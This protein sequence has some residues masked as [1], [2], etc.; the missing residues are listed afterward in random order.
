MSVPAKVEVPRGDLVFVGD[1]H[2]DRDDPHLEAFVSFLDWIG[3]TCCR[4]VFVGDLFNLWI[5]RR[6]LEGPH[7]TIVV[8]RLERLRRQGLVVRYIEG[9]RDYRIGSCYTGSA[10][11]EATSQGI[12]ECFG[13]RRVWA[14]HGDLANPGD[15]NYRTW[16]RLSRSAPAWALFHL[17]PR[18]RRLRLAA[19]LERRLRSSNLEFKRVFPAAVVCAYASKFLRSDGDTVVLGHFHVERDLELGGPGCR[20]RLLVL[21]EWKTS[22]RHLRVGADGAIGFVD[23]PT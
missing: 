20:G 14:T 4:V 23:S 11:D 8:K 10:F 3:R 2:L 15:L 9:N 12:V 1:T 16:R 13:G 22:R 6:E 19:A 18:A 17:L 5:G 21:P 7:H